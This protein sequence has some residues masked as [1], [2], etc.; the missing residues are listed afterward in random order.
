MHMCGELTLAIVYLLISHN[1][2]STAGNLDSKCNSA[3]EHNIIIRK[4]CN[5]VVIPV[6]P[7]VAL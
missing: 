2:T 6:T 3:L 4:S 5:N 1:T 7:K